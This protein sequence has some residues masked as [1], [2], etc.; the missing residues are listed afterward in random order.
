[1]RLT[2]EQILQS[3]KSTDGKYA[4]LMI[5]SLQ[6]QISL[7]DGSRI[8]AIMDCSIRNGPSFKAVV[9]I[10]TVASPQSILMAA[11]LLKTYVADKEQEDKI[12]LLIAPYIG[13][14]QA[15]ILADNGISWLDLSGNMSIRVSNRIYIERTGKPNRFPDTAP[16]KKIFQGTS[17]L[18]SRALLLKP[19][20]F[21]TLYEI[22]DFINNR[23]AKVT[24]ST[25]S[26]VLKSLEEE[27]LINRSKS[28]ISVAD[29]EK[30]L[31]RLAE[32]YKN[33]TERKR[34]NSYRFVI[35]GIEQIS[36]GITPFCKDYL[37]CGFYAAQ[38]KGLAITD[39]KT[40]FVKDIEQFRRKADIKLVSVT[41][42]A[43][44]GNVIITETDDPGVWFNP[45]WRVIDSVVDDVE[46]YLEMMV[47]TPRGPKIAEQLKRRIL[48]K[49]E[50]DGQ[51]AD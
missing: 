29:P 8:D 21:S 19:E 7:Q 38:I 45:N 47:D 2:E 9:E 14:K 23:N 16:I 40:L 18:V 36:D 49:G 34:R 6:E 17:S 5:N 41:P 15:K 42:D 39:Q 51:K 31:E 4:P 26:K 20:G 43:E 27:L 32:G 35:E 33:S 30:L 25:V 37:A 50:T 3:L 12:P 44:F 24:L 46:L 22:I 13:M 11:Q 48:Q 1:M 28:L 10:K